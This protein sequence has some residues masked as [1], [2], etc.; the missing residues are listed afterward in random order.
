MLKK[1]KKNLDETL[2]NVFDTTEQKLGIENNLDHMLQ[3]ID[4][5][6]PVLDKKK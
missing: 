1:N 4:N 5:T 3:G 6:D 2:N